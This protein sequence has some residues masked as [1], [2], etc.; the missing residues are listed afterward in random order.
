MTILIFKMGNSIN[1]A[2]QLS[3]ACAELLLISVQIKY[4][5][6]SL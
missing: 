4:P 2:Y 5:P 1:L 3:L 6:G